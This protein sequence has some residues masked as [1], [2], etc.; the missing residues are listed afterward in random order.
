[1]EAD[2]E[3]GPDV[4]VFVAVLAAGTGSR[5]GGDKQLAEY[6]G[7]TLV[8]RAV[9][10]ANQAVAGN[11]LL[12]AGHHSA[13]VIDSCRQQQGF[14]V[15]NDD[16]KAGLGSS[17]AAAVRS[18][19]ESATALILQLADQ[20]LVTPGHLKNLIEAWSG[21]PMAIV[22]SEYS[23]TV[24]PPVLFSRGAFEELALLTDDKGA[25]NLFTD[26]R[27]SV[28]RLRFE[29]AAVD[30]DTQDSLNRVVRRYS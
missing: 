28:R 2:P 23:E 18:L 20:P 10:I 25:K 9:D 5:F 26:E 22:A 4:T 7:Q 12:V 27:F 6:N 19:P 17:I 13:A 30:V 11:T 3:P 8:S 21:D 29:P 16:Y 1:M 14:A 24:G 15:V